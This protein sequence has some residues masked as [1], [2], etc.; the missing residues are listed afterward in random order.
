MRY[1][2]TADIEA[3]LV[4]FQDAELKYILVGGGAAVVHGA[5]IVTQ[6]VDIVPEQSAE[7][8]DRLA[9]VLSKLDTRFRPV[10]PGREP[11]PTVE[12]LGGPEQLNLVTRLGPIDVLGRLHDGRGYEQLWTDTVEVE[13]A[14]LKVRL[15]TLDALIQVKTATGRARD[16]LLLPVLRALRSGRG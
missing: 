11:S 7:N 12:Q 2:K 10:M 5:P 6:D 3:L 4:A 9:A 13:D 14:G 16:Q 8:V 1:P 15:L